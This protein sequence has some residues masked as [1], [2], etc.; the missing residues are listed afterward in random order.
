MELL[1]LALRVESMHHLRNLPRSA[2]VCYQQ[3]GEPVELGRQRIRK[4]RHKSHHLKNQL[5]PFNS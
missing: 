4:R 5:G 2:H 3:A 1:C